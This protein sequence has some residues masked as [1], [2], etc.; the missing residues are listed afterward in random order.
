MHF[1]AT[2]SEDADL[3]LRLA[4]QAS[5]SAA[6]SLVASMP[7]AQAKRVA[8]A[9]GAAKA[10]AKSRKGANEWLMEQ[11][12]WAMKYRALHDKFKDAF[13]KSAL[14]TATASAT[15]QLTHTQAVHPG[16]GAP[17]HIVRA[18]SP[19]PACRSLV[20]VSAVPV[21]NDCSFL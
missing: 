13:F 9:L 12:S 4:Q 14:V 18:L 7:A 19:H 20:R 6:Y 10:A 1:I 16:K 3:I 15:K 2:M 8:R 5:L 21:T 17:N 11:F